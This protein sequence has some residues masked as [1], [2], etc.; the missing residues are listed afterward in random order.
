MN[1]AVRPTS[2]PH[3]LSL[4]VAS[5]RRAI[6]AAS[7]R[8]ETAAATLIRSRSAGAPLLLSYFMRAVDDALGL[9]IPPEIRARPL[10]PRTRGH[11]GGGPQSR[12]RSARLGSS[13]SHGFDPAPPRTPCSPGRDERAR[14]P[15]LAC[16]LSDGKA[17]A[18]TGLIDIILVA[19]QRLLP[20]RQPERPYLWGAAAVRFFPQRR[21]PLPPIYCASR[22]QQKQHTEYMAA[23]QG[24]SLGSLGACPRGVGMHN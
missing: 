10:P 3:R 7:P 14:S 17:P 13:P 5:C 1:E 15:L 11:I 9:M 18:A 19:L 6:I 4:F 22:W 20:A 23:N 21:A 12:A 24:S 2:T 8:R 16:F